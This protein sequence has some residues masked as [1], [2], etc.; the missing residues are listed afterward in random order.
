MSQWPEDT[1]LAEAVRWVLKHR[2]DGVQCPCC[3][4]FAKIY[5]R[6]L[7]AAMAQALVAFYEK[8]LGS[9]DFVH[10]PSTTDMSRLGGDWAKL[11]HWKL[12]EEKPEDR[13]DGCKHAGWWRI[14]DLGR[15]FVR[16]EVRI[17]SHVL[18]YNQSLLG[19]DDSA[20]ISI[21]EALGDRFDYAELMARLHPP[22]PPPVRPAAG[23]ARV[24][25]SLLPEEDATCESGSG[26][27]TAR[28]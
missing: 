2:T 28:T 17:A 9:E 14:T 13:H 18:L 10:V 1:L 27:S 15:R 26:S 12:I 21:R 11:V 16:D 24:Q 22:P 25:L 6:K 7:N 8:V 23:H 3:G 5:R 19:L 4:Q 20:S